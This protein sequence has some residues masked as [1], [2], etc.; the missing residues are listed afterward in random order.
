M[1]FA[2]C[3]LQN[4]I[5]MLTDTLQYHFCCSNGNLNNTDNF[6]FYIFNFQFPENGNKTD[7]FNQQKGE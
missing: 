5:G 3:D 1:Y 4:R 7:R 2:D 6:Q